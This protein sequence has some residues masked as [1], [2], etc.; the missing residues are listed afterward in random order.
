MDKELC[1]KI[2]SKELMLVEVLVDYDD[3]PVY[4]ICKDETECY[5]VALCTD[6]DNDKY[7]VVK[8]D[9]DKIF[10]LLTSKMTMREMI[11]LENEF[12]EISA[13]ENIDLDICIQKNISDIDFGVLPCQESYFNLVTKT[14]KKF[15]EEIK[16]LKHKA[17]VW[18]EVSSNSLVYNEFLGDNELLYQKIDNK[19]TKEVNILEIRKSISI[20]NKV[21]KDFNDKNYVTYCTESIK[22]SNDF[23]KKFDGYNHELSLAS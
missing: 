5:Y 17:D 15:L 7:V 19:I 13:A 23:T 20:Y 11:T 21:N 1:F 16:S 3:I 22:I 10:K 8:T 12:W 2:N 4:F 6:I 14:H 18:K 9:I